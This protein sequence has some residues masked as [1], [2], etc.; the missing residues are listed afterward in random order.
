MCGALVRIGNNCDQTPAFFGVLWAW[1]FSTNFAEVWVHEKSR[2]PT[3]HKL[4]FFGLVFVIIVSGFRRS[5]TPPATNKMP[6]KDKKPTTKQPIIVPAGFS[7]YSTTPPAARLAGTD[8]RAIRK[9][10]EE[11]QHQ[12]QG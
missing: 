9:G 5:T 8:A 6:K 3:L 12:Q 10:Q 11:Q 2:I 4:V 1:E 7:A